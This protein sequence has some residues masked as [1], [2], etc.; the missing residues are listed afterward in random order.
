MSFFKR[1]TTKSKI[2]K[3]I[4]TQNGI[5][6]RQYLDS[7]AL[8]RNFAVVLFSGSEFVSK[9]IKT[10]EK[11]ESNGC[12]STLYKI[13]SHCGV[14]LS[15]EFVEHPNARLDRWYVMEMTCSGKFANDSTVDIMTGAGKFGLQ[16]RDLEQ[17]C[18]TYK[19]DICIL[20]LTEEVFRNMSQLSEVPRHTKEEIMRF[21]QMYKDT[22]YQFNLVRLF[23]SNFRLL[24]VF[25]PL[26]FGKKWKMCSDMVAT[27]YKSLTIFGPDVISEDVV[28][29]DFIFDV[30]GEIPPTMF[31]LPPIGIKLYNNV[32]LKN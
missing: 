17:V 2:I 15:G 9:C 23:A 11:L 19:G 12:Y 29:Q 21:Y 25:R 1:K 31:E 24:R 16:I 5:I 28:P 32:M 7:T 18:E 4:S 14:L 30:D 10:L 20:N 3:S 13:W 26:S 22:R 6:F 8:F 27:F